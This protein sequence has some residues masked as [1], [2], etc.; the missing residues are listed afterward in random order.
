MTTVNYISRVSTQRVYSIS[1]QP[2][3]RPHSSV[4]VTAEMK[5]IVPLPFRGHAGLS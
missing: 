5:A 1:K 4:T 3:H 2:D